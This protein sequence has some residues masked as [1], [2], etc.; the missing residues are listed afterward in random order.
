MDLKRKPTET[1]TD[2]KINEI[3]LKQGLVDYVRTG[4]VRLGHLGGI[5]V[6]VFRE[7]V[8]LTATDDIS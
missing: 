8:I 2:R 6:K 7:L 5:G 1:E 4:Y 3:H